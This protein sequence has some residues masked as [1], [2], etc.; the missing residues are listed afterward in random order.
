[1]PRAVIDTGMLSGR[2]V[3]TFESQSEWRNVCADMLTATPVITLGDSATWVLD[4]AMQ[5]DSLAALKAGWD[6]YGGRPLNEK[7]KEIA[8]GTLS[9][10]KTTNLP[11]PCVALG[12]SGDV[13]FEWRRDG[14]QLDLDVGDD[15]DAVEFV[16]VDP[17]GHITEGTEKTDWRRRVL[18]LAGWLIY[19]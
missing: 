14:R 6:S 4:A 17:T 8:F 7:A 12:S 19:G 13:Q 10:L 18:L 2:D 11:V 9:I 3:K 1:M 16:T 5:L 15:A